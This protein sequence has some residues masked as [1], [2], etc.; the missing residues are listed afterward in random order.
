M[1]KESNNFDLY[2]FDLFDTLITR[3]L[4]RPSDIFSLVQFSGI[5]KY[6]VS[7]FSLISFRKW[8]I[9]AEKI[10]RLLSR[11]EEIT[12]FDIYRLLGTILLNPAETLKKEISVELASVRIINANKLKLTRLLDENKKCCII[13]DMY[14]PQGILR[15]MLKSVGI[16]DV[17]ILVSSQYKKTKSSGNLF[18][19]ASEIY[20]VSLNRIQ[21]TG[22]NIH[23]DVEI[24]KKL[25]IDTI[26]I[27]SAKYQKSNNIWSSFQSNERLSA[28]EA[29]GY[30]IVGP[31]SIAF[32]RFIAIKAKDK[33][34]SQI[35][36]GA[37]DGYF[38]KLAYDKFYKDL[39]RIE[40]AYVR[41]S[42]SSVYIPEAVATN[43]ILKFF[44]GSISGNDFFKRIGIEA[45]SHL[46]DKPVKGNEK[47]FL[48]ALRSMRFLEIEGKRQLITMQNYLKSN[49][50]NE[51]VSFVD[52]GW[53]GS[54]QDSIENILGKPGQIFGIYLGTTS[55]Q[56]NK[57]GFI[58]KKRRPFK[59][60]FSIMQAISSF[61]FLFTEPAY[62]L[63]KLESENDSSF[64]YKFIEDEPYSQIL[65]RQEIEKGVRRFFE[66][67]R[68]FS[69]LLHPKEK[70]ENREIEKLIQESFLNP[71][72]DFI[73]S[74]SNITHSA[75]FG[76]T[77]T[78][79]GVKKEFHP[80]FL[81]YANSPWKSVY[82]QQLYEHSKFTYYFYNAFI[83]TSLFF[84]FYDNLKIV[85][86]KMRLYV[87]QKI[88]KRAKK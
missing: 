63:L 30:S 61:E 11:N 81:S 18:L 73:E 46:M 9:L 77:Q 85:Y 88:D 40:S 15:K 70:T 82:M 37:R 74:I 7:I 4:G 21:H 13:S 59:N 31:I 32:S 83:H 10:S 65:I 69:S 71:S 62:S 66:E 34:S 27:G 75:G 51:N 87:I 28:A 72:S 5:I 64:K 2:S 60:Y 42:R 52:L 47:C 19:K 44:E 56:K 29:I 54:I 79:E 17:D 26:H 53:R 25:G 48:D 6:R 38:L 67:Y 12:I 14:L 86:R 49:G 57:I 23:A 43:N 39:Y 35:I 20:Q 33:N 8:R 80:S 22:D 78:S 36:F 24:P 55:S 76:G 16:T 68:N 1:S 84:N 3:P 58:F 50:F 45:P 41:I